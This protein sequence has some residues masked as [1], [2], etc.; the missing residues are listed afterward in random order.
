MIARESSLRQS[1]FIR[2]RARVHA[3]VTAAPI[4]IRRLARPRARIRRP[5]PNPIL[6]WGVRDPVALRRPP[7]R[8][9]PRRP[10]I[11]ARSTDASL[12]IRIV[13]RV[14]R[15]P[16]MFRASPRAS[17]SVFDR[18]PFA[19]RVAHSSPTHRNGSNPLTAPNCAR[20]AVDFCVARARATT[21]GRATL[22]SVCA[23]IVSSRCAVVDA[24]RASSRGVAR[25]F[26]PTPR[27]LVT[28]KPIE[29]SRSSS[30]PAPRHRSVRHSGRDFMRCGFIVRALSR[31]ARR[32]SR[33]VLYLKPMYYA[34]R[35]RGR[36]HRIRR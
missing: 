33:I 14:P 10:P 35:A 28:C 17:S 31:V 26:R 12:A 19:S 18:V 5:A 34:R 2:P 3:A 16:R 30:P 21:R 25:L 27:S 24:S 29:T 4:L 15:V 9:A 1:S 23:I 22:E 32:S 36:R 20:A 7:A 13:S 6:S 8:R 11:P